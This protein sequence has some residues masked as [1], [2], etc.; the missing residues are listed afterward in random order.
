MLE[1]LEAE[2]R[3]AANAALSAQERE[4][5]RIARD[6]HDEVNQALTGAAAPARGRCAARPPIPRSWPSSRRSARSISRAMQELLD[7]ARRLRPTTLDDLGLKAALATLVEEVEQEAGHR[8]RLRG[9]GRARRPPRRG[10]ARH[11][12]GRPG[13]RDERRPARRRRAPPGPPD[14]R[15]RRARAAGQRRRRPATPAA[16]RRAARNRRDA[17]ARA[18]SAGAS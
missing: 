17:G 5:E 13:G 7:L 1:R 14:R 8:G 3:G 2:R 12:P 9:R 16:A 15:R 11:L 4:R 18:C 6:L 10:P